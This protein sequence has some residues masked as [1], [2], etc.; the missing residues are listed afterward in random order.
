MCDSI[1]YLELID[2]LRLCASG[3]DTIRDHCY[4]KCINNNG[5]FDPDC[6]E[7]LMS[8]SADALEKLLATKKAAPAATGTARK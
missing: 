1:N 2:R 4:E 3:V 8:Q 7:K 6:C 5:Q